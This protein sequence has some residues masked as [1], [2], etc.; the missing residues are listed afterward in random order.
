MV[1]PHMV[2]KWARPGT[3][4]CRSL[5]WPATSVTSASAFRLIGPRVREGSG[6]PDLMS[7][8]SQWNRL[9]AR[10]KPMTVTPMPRM[11]LIGT[12]A[13]RLRGFTNAGAADCE[14]NPGELCAGERIVWSAAR[15]RS[16]EAE[17]QLPKLR[18]RVRFS[19]PALF[20]LRRSPSHSVSEISLPE[21]SRMA[22]V[23]QRAT[24]NPA[25]SGTRAEDAGRKC[26]VTNTKRLLIPE[27]SLARVVSQQID[28]RSARRRGTKVPPRSRD[29]SQ[30]GGLP[31]AGLGPLDSPESPT[32]MQVWSIRTT[33]PS[34]GVP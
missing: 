13:P 9:A 24:R 8:D 21:S 27:C 26:L 20:G 34:S 1:K 22:G 30:Q 6:L 31:T 17:H 11:I 33:S 3:V 29:R 15:G 32:A 5:R 10:P 12:N 28:Q 18:T 19:S 16:S 2:K 7:L 25:I 23:P 14:R 4:H